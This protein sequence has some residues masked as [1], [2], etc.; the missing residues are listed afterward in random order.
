M[1]T[2]TQRALSSHQGL[3]TQTVSGFAFFVPS[4][5]WPG[6]KRHPAPDWATAANAPLRYH[7]R[8]VPTDRR[9]F[10]SEEEFF[11]KDCRKKRSESNVFKWRRRFCGMLNGLCGNPQGGHVCACVGLRIW[12]SSTL[13]R[14]CS[15]L[16]GSCESRLNKPM[17]ITPP[18]ICGT[19]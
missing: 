14:F 4:P 2:A 8:T 12:V 1:A 7:G 15:R 3:R 18:L 13:M 11:E 6:G 19:R 17:A 9:K 16:G 10:D 5:G